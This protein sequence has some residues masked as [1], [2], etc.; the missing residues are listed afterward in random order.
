MILIVIVSDLATTR[1]FPWMSSTRLKE[2]GVGGPR[3]GTIRLVIVGR[4]VGAGFE[5]GGN[6]GGV[7]YT[8]VLE[9]MVIGGIVVVGG[10][11]VGGKESVCMFVS[12][13]F[14]AQAEFPSPEFEWLY[15]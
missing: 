7:G 14:I 2:M 15:M 6:V 5:I 3:V 9:S 1:P 13:M 11:V 12:I 8:V 4:K 10:G